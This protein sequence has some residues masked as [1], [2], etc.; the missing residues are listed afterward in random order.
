MI[1]E[2]VYSNLFNQLIIYLMS[3]ISPGKRK[4]FVVIKLNI[5]FRANIA[6]T[7]VII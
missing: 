7:N 2:F 4:N 6:A 1:S 3:F 5:S